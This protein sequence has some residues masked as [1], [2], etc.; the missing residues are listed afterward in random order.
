V[1]KKAEI[2]KQEDLNKKNKEEL[3]TE[4]KAEKDRSKKQ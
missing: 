2:K 4:E 1:I 3:E